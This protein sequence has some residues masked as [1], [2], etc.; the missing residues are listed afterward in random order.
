MTSLSPAPTLFLD[1]SPF[2]FLFTVIVA[3]AGV[4]CTKAASC[5]NLLK[6]R[7]RLDPSV[8]DSS[9]PQAGLATGISST[10]LGRLTLT[11]PTGTISRD[12]PQNLFFHFMSGAQ[13]G[14]GQGAAEIRPE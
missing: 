9:G 1:I 3:N 8:P 5:C 2:F 6:L 14:E 13:L 10:H 12:L 4:T 7:A 11:V